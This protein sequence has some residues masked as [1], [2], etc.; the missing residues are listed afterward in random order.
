MININ[1]RNPSPIYEQVKD[2][3]RRLIITGV[4]APGDK[5]A[6]VRELAA[7]LAINPNTIQRAYRELEAEGYIYSVH[8]KGS[9]AA[10]RREV[11][12]NRKREL[13]KQF[14]EVASELVYL[15]VTAEELKSRLDSIGRK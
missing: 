10:E 13:L 2:S 7:Q 4:L 5:L 8:G 9:F 1:Y 14:D 6:S 11:D 12:E 15:N 3:I